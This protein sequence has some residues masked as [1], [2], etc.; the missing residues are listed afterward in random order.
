MIEMIYFFPALP[1][2]TP[3]SKF[4]M[5]TSARLPVTSGIYLCKMYFFCQTYHANVV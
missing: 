1:E 4:K 2:M 5:T 3:Q